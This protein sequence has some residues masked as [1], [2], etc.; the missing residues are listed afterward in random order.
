MAYTILIGGY[1][2]EQEIT[3]VV[4][5]SLYPRQIDQ[6]QGVA[7]AI[8]YHNESAALRLIIDEWVELKSQIKAAELSAAQED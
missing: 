1:M 4:A 7:Q 5:Y 6:I 8:T 3:R 2:K